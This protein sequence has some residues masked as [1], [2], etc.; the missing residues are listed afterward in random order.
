MSNPATELLKRIRSMQSL[1]KDYQDMV[2]LLKAMDENQK[3]N[4]MYYDP[5]YYGNVEKRMLSLKEK[6][7][8]LNKVLSMVEM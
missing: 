5:V 4:N 8:R 2:V 7:E 6:I 3:V 1:L